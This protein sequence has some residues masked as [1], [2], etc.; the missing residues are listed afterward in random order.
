MLLTIINKVLV[1]LFFLACLTALRHGYYII[2]ASLTS[3][4]E[5]PRKYVLSKKTLL[6]LGLSV[7]YILSTIFTG[8]QI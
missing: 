6:L 7:A 2:Q 1:V 5:N 3:T 4:E 8:I